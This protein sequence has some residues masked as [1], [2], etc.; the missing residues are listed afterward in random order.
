MPPFG[1]LSRRDLVRGLRQAGFDGP[2]TGGKHSFLV[3]DDLTLAIPNPHH[4]DIGRGLL[5]RIIR[6]AGI[7]RKEWE[8]LG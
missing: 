5:A 4:R 6:L 2:Y 3:K 7:S 8:R 1:P